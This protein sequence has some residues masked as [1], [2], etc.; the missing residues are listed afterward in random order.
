VYEQVGLSAS[1]LMTAFN[2]LVGTKMAGI[3]VAG[4]RLG[5]VRK[6]MPGK[7]SNIPTS[8]AFNT[9]CDVPTSGIQTHSMRERE[10]DTMSPAIK[11]GDVRR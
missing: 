9:P 10:R 2:M 3:S 11:V 1:L 8:L 4:R 7:P 6:Q 5:A